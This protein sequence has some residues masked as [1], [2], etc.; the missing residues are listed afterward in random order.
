MNTFIIYLQGYLWYCI[1]VMPEVK[2]QSPWFYS[3]LELCLVP[4]TSVRQEQYN[5]LLKELPE[6]PVQGRGI[7]MAAKCCSIRV[8]SVLVSG[9]FRA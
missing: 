1:A 6:S 8:A 7:F 2:S 4:L 9:H 5:N 3:V